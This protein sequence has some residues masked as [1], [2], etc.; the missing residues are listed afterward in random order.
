MST[1]YEAKRFNDGREDIEDDPCPGRPSTSSNVNKATMKKMIM[2]DRWITVR[3]VT[4]DIDILIN[5][6]HAIVSDILVIKSFAAKP[7]QVQSFEE[8]VTNIDCFDFNDVVHHKLLLQGQRSMMSTL[9]E[10]LAK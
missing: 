2:G 3:E 9:N 5:S 1:C 4:D 10:F 6:W 8:V 7:R